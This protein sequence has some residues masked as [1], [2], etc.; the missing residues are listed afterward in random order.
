MNLKSLATPALLS[1]F[2]ACGGGGGSDKPAP[3]APVVAPVISTFTA[4]ATTVEYGQPVTLSWT[5]GGDAATSVTLTNADGSAM[6]CTPAVTSTSTSTVVTPRKRQ[7]VRLTATNSAGTVTRDINLVSLGVDT[8]SSTLFSTVGQ[9]AKDPSGNIYMV[10]HTNFSHIWKITPSGVV[11]NF[12]GL[13][14]LTYPGAI[15]WSVKD[16]AFLVTVQGGMKKV[17]LAGTITDLP[18]YPYFSYITVAKDGT[19]YGTPQGIG[20][21]ITKIDPNGTFSSITGGDEFYPGSLVL[22]ATETNL[23]VMGGA[24]G[25]ETVEV[26][27]MA[28]VRFSYSNTIS[29]V[30]LSNNS[31]TVVAGQFEVGGHADGIG[32]A[33]TFQ[34]I[35][36]ATLSNDGTAIY[37][38]DAR[39]GLIRK[40]DLATA[41]VSTVVGT[42][43][44]QPYTGATPFQ[45]G[46]LTSAEFTPVGLVQN[47]AGDLVVGAAMPSINGIITA[48]SP[49]CV[50]TLP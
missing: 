41:T 8:Y 25:S 1:L 42:L 44:P 36:G 7:T 12:V 50:V 33:A 37:L 19:I 16:N 18:G 31:I 30:D 15:A 34:V 29:K 2:I 45:A 26:D 6:T 17:D 47:T 40:L 48:N 46:S 10:D 49:V 13:N 43:S 11:W 35:G 14:V 20:H 38:T 3:P 28:A 22:D 9:L 24:S 21:T 27:G 23:Y 39:N 32:T 4:S 5:L